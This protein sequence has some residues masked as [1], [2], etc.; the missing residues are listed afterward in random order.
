[1]ELKY[2]P[3]AIFDWLYAIWITLTAKEPKSDAES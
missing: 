2:L 1:M 3:R